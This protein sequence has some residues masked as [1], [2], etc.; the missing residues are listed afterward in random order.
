MCTVLIVF[1]KNSRLYR[2]EIDNFQICGYNVA[3]DNIRSYKTIV[4]VV[5]K[6]DQGVMFA[7]KVCQCTFN[8]VK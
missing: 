3:V 1:I 7:L 6:A 8:L 2:S 5:L 4:V